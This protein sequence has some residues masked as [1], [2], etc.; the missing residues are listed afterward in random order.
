MTAPIR[1][2][3]IDDHCLV[4]KGIRVLLA[5]EADIEVVGEAGDGVSAVTEAVRLQPDVLLMDLVMPVMD[6]IEA[7]RRVHAANPAART[8]VLT[9]FASDDKLYPAIRAG[10]LGY[11]LKDLEP[12]DL[13]AAIRHVHHG[14]VTLHPDIARKVLDEATHTV[15]DPTAT[16]PLTEREV[17]VLQLAA[18]GWSNQRIATE[19]HL[20]ETTI[21][22]HM[23]NLLSKLHFASR[24]QAVLYA[25]RE[26]LASLSDSSEDS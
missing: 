14:D 23:S 5:E 26:G 11:L 18:R 22:T 2:M 7:I 13:I 10:A 20:S 6:G 4:R 24:T 16:V 17:K 8:L 1:V 21:R 15:T 12:E 19:L 25:L 9:S 3:I